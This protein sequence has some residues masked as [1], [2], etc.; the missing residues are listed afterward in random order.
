VSS[1]SKRK[2][3]AA[4]EVY[5][6][7]RGLWRITVASRKEEV[8]S[9]AESKGPGGGVRLALLADGGLSALARRR[10]AG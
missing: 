8:N 9:L 4:A 6:D 7:L 10:Q 3:F 2:R 5:R 1:T